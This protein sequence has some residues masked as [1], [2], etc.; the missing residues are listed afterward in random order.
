MCSVDVC[1]LWLYVFCGCM[2]SVD[3]YVHIKTCL[4]NLCKRRYVHVL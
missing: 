3:V 1:V 2:C 4:Y